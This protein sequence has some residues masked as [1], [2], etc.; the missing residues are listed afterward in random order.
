MALN[1]RFWGVFKIVCSGWCITASVLKLVETK[2]TFKR[3]PIQKYGFANFVKHENSTLNVT[4]AFSKSVKRLGD[5]GLQC[6]KYSTGLSFNFRVHPTIQGWFIC[7][8]LDTDKYSDPTKFLTNV[9]GSVHYSIS[10]SF[11]SSLVRVL[12]CYSLVF[13]QITTSYT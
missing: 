3:D 6:A 13:F 4:A 8:V 5:C 11:L 9:L 12:L 2:N 10:V 7:E 1:M